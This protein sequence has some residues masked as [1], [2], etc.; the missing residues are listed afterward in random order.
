MNAEPHS[1]PYWRLLSLS[2]GN[3][4]PDAWVASAVLVGAPAIGLRR[5]RTARGATAEEAVASLRRGLVGD[6]DGDRL[7]LGG[8]VERR[9]ARP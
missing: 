1:A 9:E 4:G 8:F 5:S 2:E 3:P 6:P 7:D